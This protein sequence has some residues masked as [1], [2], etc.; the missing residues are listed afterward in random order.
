[1]RGNQYI[2]LSLLYEKEVKNE[3]ILCSEVKPSIDSSRFQTLILDRRGLLLFFLN[4][5]CVVNEDLKS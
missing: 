2:K 4:Q 1:M 3:N 5:N